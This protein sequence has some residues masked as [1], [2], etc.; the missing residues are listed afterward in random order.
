M[1]FS[2]PDALKVLSAAQASRSSR[3]QAA[4][5]L[6]T[7]VNSWAEGVAWSK[8]R[9]RLRAM[10]KEDA[11][12]IIADIAQQVAECVLTT[13][14][15]FGGST[16]A[17]A[18]RYVQQ[19]FA[20]KLSDF[21]KT[22]DA[23]RN[24]RDRFSESTVPPDGPSSARGV[25]DGGAGDLGDELIAAIG[26]LKRFTEAVRGSPA[27]G[28][29]VAA[30]WVA[31]GQ[32]AGMTIPEQMAALTAPSN[33]R[34]QRE[35]RIY[36]L[37]TRGNFVIRQALRDLSSKANTGDDM[38][39]SQ[40]SPRGSQEGRSRDDGG[41]KRSTLTVRIEATLLDALKQRARAVGRSVTSELVLLLRKHME[42]R[43]V[44]P[45]LKPRDRDALSGE[46]E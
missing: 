17:E 37:R 11:G 6:V 42:S 26:V 18:R 3:E 35:A 21:F 23:Q 39:T 15:P 2:L 41:P 20:R 22:H 45:L 8:Q 32:R 10:P 27:I 34:S 12:A 33:G 44:Q 46:A 38:Q 30:F 14:A 40:V 9:S 29:A 24:L 43:G 5:V 31:L 25:V 28:T 36:R 16:E 4:R 13:K 1:A 19:I 7:D